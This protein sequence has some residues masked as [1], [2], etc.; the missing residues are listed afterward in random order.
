MGF[1]G[2]SVW[3]INPPKCNYFPIPSPPLHVMYSAGGGLEG[4]EGGGSQSS[5]RLNHCSRGTKYT[6]QRVR[7]AGMKLGTHSPRASRDVSLLLSQPSQNPSTSL[8]SGLT[9]LS[10]PLK[11]YFGGC[12]TRNYIFEMFTWNFLE[13]DWQTKWINQGVYLKQHTLGLFWIH[14]AIYT[15]SKY[16]VG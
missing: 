13:N 6:S 2:L 8:K 9:L 16:L 15:K 3:A 5:S 1:K 10:L 7:P 4:V 14:C 11:P 12:A